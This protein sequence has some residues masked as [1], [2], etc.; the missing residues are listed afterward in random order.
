MSTRSRSRTKNPMNQMYCVVW[1]GNEND[2]KNDF[3]YN[4][5]LF[6]ERV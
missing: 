6:R 3:E 4:D 2:G 5:L 1:F